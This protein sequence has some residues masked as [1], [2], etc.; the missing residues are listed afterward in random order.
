MA[1]NELLLDAGEDP[2]GA[3]AGERVI[4]TIVRRPFK[5]AD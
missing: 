1:K 2:S 4:Q 5:A 3:D